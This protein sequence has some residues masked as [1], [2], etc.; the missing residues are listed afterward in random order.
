MQMIS[1]FKSTAVCQ[2][3]LIDY[4]FIL[5]QS[6]I[7]SSHITPLQFQKDLQDHIALSQDSEN[8]CKV[9]FWGHFYKNYH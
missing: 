4:Y 5:C 9:K 7:L 1:V 3:S 8:Y 2:T 6:K